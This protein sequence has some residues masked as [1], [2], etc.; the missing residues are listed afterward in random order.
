MTELFQAAWSLFVICGVVWVVVKL[1]RSLWG[2][3]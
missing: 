2:P 3:R 1:T